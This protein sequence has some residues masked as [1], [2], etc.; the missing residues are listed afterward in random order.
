MGCSNNGK[1]WLGLGI[2]AT[3]GVL[4]YYLAQTQKGKQLQKDVLN[5]LEDIEVK[6]A[7]QYDCAKKKVQETASK[8]SA[9]VNEGIAEAKRKYSQTA[10]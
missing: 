6:A 5:A 3:M 2:G 4:G 10:D 9:Q 1:F 7:N 8:V